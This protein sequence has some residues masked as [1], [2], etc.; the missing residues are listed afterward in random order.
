MKRSKDKQYSF[1]LDTCRRVAK[2]KLA[3]VGAV[4]LVLLI[5]AAVFADFIAPYSETEMDLTGQFQLPSAQ[6]LFGTDNYGRDIFSRVVYGA[7]ISLFIGFIAIGISVVGGA[8]LGAVAGYYGKACDMIIMRVM[9]VLAAI[10][11]I[12]LAIA[13]VAALGSG[14]RNMMIATGISFMPGFARIVRASVLSLR[15]Q[16]FIEAS[17]A[18]GSRDSTII[19]RHVLPNCLAPLFV[20][21]TFGVALAILTVAG[22]SFIGLGL[23][24][25][26]PEWGSMLSVGRDFIRDYPHMTIFPGLAIAVTIFSLNALGDGLRD[27][28]DP[29]LRD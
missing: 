26:S 3:V 23:Q 28:L 9:D 29:K 7:R 22:L 16:D 27:A 18:I 2:N 20:Q 14:L 6:H 25:P 4:L 12:L 10:P 5:L 17:R 24:P 8:L 13:I 19:L 1:F 15:D 11:T 21:T